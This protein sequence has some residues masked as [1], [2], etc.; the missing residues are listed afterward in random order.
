MHGVL[1]ADHPT[2]FL[3]KSM[4]DHS[5][6]QLFV[7][8]LG[9]LTHSTDLTSRVPLQEGNLLLVLDLY[10]LGLPNTA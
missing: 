6:L 4:I 3:Y 9:N 10:G 1:D 2:G 7:S 5:T 8:C